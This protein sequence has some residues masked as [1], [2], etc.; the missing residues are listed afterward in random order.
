MSD[1]N[2]YDYKMMDASD[3]Y[4]VPV[5]G[6][7]GI[8]SSIPSNGSAYYSFKDAYGQCSTITYVRKSCE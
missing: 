3:F 5:F 4:V 6:G 8:P 7:C 1:C 2:I